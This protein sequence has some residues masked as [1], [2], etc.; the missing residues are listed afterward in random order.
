MLYHCRW[1]WWLGGGV[2]R[3]RVIVYDAMLD[4]LFLTFFAED[5][6]DE[7]IRGGGR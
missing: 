3:T 7:S 4:T 2:L 5:G 6:G 1:L